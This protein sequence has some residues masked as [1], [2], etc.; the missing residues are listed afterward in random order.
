ML[1]Y[2]ITMISEILLDI[3]DKNDLADMQGLSI[4][5]DILSTWRVL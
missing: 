1:Q 2:A 4:E 3:G 5:S